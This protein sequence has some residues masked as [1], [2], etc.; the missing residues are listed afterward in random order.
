ML[1]RLQGMALL[2][3]LTIAFNASAAFA[4]KESAEWVGQVYDRAVALV[5]KGDYP[6]AKAEAEKLVSSQRW[7][8]G[9]V[10]VAGALRG[11]SDEFA[12][13]KQGDLAKWLLTESEKAHKATGNA[14]LA[15]KGLT[16]PR[17][18]TKDFPRSPVIAATRKFNP[19]RDLKR[20]RVGNQAS[21]LKVMD[22]DNS[23]PMFV[24]YILGGPALDGVMWAPIY[25]EHRA[26]TWTS[27]GI[28]PNGLDALANQMIGQYNK[29]ISKEGI[30]LLGYIGSTPGNAL[31][32]ATRNAIQDYLV[33]AMKKSKNP[34]NRR[35]ALLAL[36][37]LADVNEKTVNEVTAFY[38]QSYNP[39]EV[40][41]ITQFFEYHKDYVKGLPSYAKIKSNIQAV[42]SF[43]TPGILA[44]L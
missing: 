28:D 37:L 11:I 34:I 35:Q 3:I 15:L 24:K 30:A 19:G 16:V 26:G 12:A 33:I 41:P 21:I 7:K 14:S 23:K 9:D 40:F 4:Q 43:Y 20:I 8:S 42:D 2:L 17:L 29:G 1:R 13:A 44:I 39:Y 38:G 5:D 10:V 25:D 18:V 36:A 22:D 27:L 32:P 31:T 6:A